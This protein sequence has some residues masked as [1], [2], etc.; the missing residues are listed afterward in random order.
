[1]TTTPMT[2]P[3]HPT[4]PRPGDRMAVLSP[5]SGLP[6]LFPQPYELGLR[7]LRDEFD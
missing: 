1:M 5:S 6:A 2:A 3:V 4:K 7:R